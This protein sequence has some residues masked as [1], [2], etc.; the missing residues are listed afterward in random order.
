MCIDL[1]GEVDVLERDVLILIGRVLLDHYLQKKRMFFAPKDL[2]LRAGKPSRQR[3]R[4]P[5]S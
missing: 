5:A 1:K 3:R 2:H 4:F